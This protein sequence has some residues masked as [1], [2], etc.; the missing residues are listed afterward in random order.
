MLPLFGE[1]NVT[2]PRSRITLIAVPVN[3]GPVELNKVEIEICWMEDW[4]QNEE[5]EVHFGGVL[6]LEREHTIS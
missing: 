4:G 6:C 5:Y 3:R 1:W 2:Y